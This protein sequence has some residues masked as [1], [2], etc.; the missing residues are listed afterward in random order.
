MSL[1]RF[2]IVLGLGTVLSWSAWVLVV[3]LLDPQTGGVIALMLFYSSLFLALL[4]T[5]T[6]AG[7]FLRYWLEKETLIFQQV[8]IALR[9]AT[10]LSGGATIALMLQSQRLL[11]IWVFLS[12][13]IVLFVIEGF[14]LAGQSERHHQTSQSSSH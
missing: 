10:L 13:A 9:Q 2:L 1:V 7:F 8:S 5:L 6:L 14:F 3:A 4:G 12:L 11:N